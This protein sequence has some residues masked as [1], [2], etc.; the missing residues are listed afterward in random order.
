MSFE[1]YK[2][3]ICPVSLQIFSDPVSASD[4]HIYERALIEKVIKTTGIS[5]MTR[6]KLEK[7]VY[8]VLHMKNKIEKLLKK[9]PELGEDQYK[10]GT[11]V[12]TK[13]DFTQYR[14]ECFSFI[15]DH[16][17]DQLLNY[18]NFDL[19]CDSGYYFN[20]F[21]DNYF[22]NFYK[23]C[24]DEK[25]L[26]YV[27]DNTPDLE[28]KNCEGQRIIHLICGFSTPN[29]VRYIIDKGVHLECE[30]DDGWRPI[31]YSCSFSTPDSIRLL[32]DKGVNL[33]CQTGCRNGHYPIHMICQRSDPEMI[34]YFID[35]GVDLECVDKNGWRPIHVICRYSTPEMIRYII[36]KGVDLECKTSD[37]WEPIHF[38]CYHSTFET[39]QYIIEKGVSLTGVVNKFD[40]CEYIKMNCIELI[41]ELYKEYNGLSLEEFTKFNNL[42]SLKMYEE[43]I[44]KSFEEFDKDTKAE[45]LHFLSTF[46][47]KHLVV[48]HEDVL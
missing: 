42:L 36:D 19:T 3:Y 40:G 37:G 33:D 30:D 12:G 41:K 6:E 9:H 14:E 1:K 34:R 15:I 22:A 4:G 21:E 47:V 7:R 45:A 39:L 5:P 26:K 48:E 16:K 13:K 46:L 17:F 29:M 25:I 38:I 24:K 23:K 35:K 2:K 31:H 18:T 44:T 10:V 28:T 27:I 20:R 32:V 43:T 8:P 11:K